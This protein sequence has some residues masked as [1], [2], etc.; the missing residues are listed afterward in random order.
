MLPGRSSLDACLLLGRDGRAKVT[1]FGLARVLG[2]PNGLGSGCVVVGTAD[3][4]SPEQARGLTIDARWGMGQYSALR[5][6]FQW[7]LYVDRSRRR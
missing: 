2:D 5:T 1:D 6:D 3:Y 7:Q 4:M